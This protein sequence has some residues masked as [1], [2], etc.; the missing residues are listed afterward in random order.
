L[1]SIG[2]YRIRAF[3][4]LSSFLDDIDRITAERYVPSVGQSHPPPQ[5]GDILPL[6][7]DFTTFDITEDVLKA[8]LKT[9]GVSEHKF[10]IEIGQ[11]F[12]ARLSSILL[13]LLP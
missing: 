2:F 5:S 7:S 4:P 12:I 10:T 8:R 1:D 3:I 13:S 9:I 11:H 6:V